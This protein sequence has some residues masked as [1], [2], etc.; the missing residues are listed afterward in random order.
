MTAKFFA[1]VQRLVKRENPF[2]VQSQGL[3]PP[4]PAKVE[5]TIQTGSDAIR[6]EPGPEAN[7]WTVSWDAI[8]CVGG[9]EYQTNQDLRRADLWSSRVR[10]DAPRATF[11]LSADTTQCWLRVRAITLEGPGP[12]SDPVLIGPGDNSLERAA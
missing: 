3:T 5:Q 4:P 12:W 7:T 11:A 10:T 2:R 9:Y 6:V 1:A 8:Q